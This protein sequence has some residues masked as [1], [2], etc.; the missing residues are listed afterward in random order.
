MAPCSLPSNAFSPAINASHALN[1]CA[2][3]VFVAG[4]RVT[5]LAKPQVIAG[6]RQLGPLSRARAYWKEH[7]QL[8]TLLAKIRCAWRLSARLTEQVRSCPYRN[9]WRWKAG[10]DLITVPQELVI[11]TERLQRSRLVHDADKVVYS[12]VARLPGSSQSLPSALALFLMK[13]RIIVAR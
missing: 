4:C 6:S 8:H 13:A 1:T 10:E 7:V 3:A 12:R 11:S 5:L 9:V 2:L